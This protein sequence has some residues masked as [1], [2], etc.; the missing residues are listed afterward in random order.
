MAIVFPDPP[1]PDPP[2][3]DVTFEMQVQRENTD[4]FIA[5]D[6]R[7]IVLVPHTRVRTA[8]GGSKFEAGSPRVVQRFR[9]ILRT[10]F[11]KPTPTEDGKERVFD[12]TLLGS[13]NAEMDIGDRWTDSEGQKFEIVEFVPFNGY[14]RK[15][16]VVKHGH[17]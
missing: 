1:I 5:F 13:W 16:L 6:A 15:A 17:G 11:T 8:S 9:I 14:E 2:D 10:D 3:V 7:D 12:L 4:W